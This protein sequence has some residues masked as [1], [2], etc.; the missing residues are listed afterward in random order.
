[1]NWGL[2]A[3]FAAIVALVAV[4][5]VWLRRRAEAELTAPGGVRSGDAE[6]PSGPAGREPDV[7]QRHE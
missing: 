5:N 2:L 4:S 7:V 1:L 3:L 6:G